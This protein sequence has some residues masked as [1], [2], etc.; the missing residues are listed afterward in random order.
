VPRATHLLAEHADG[1]TVRAIVDRL[2]WSEETIMRL[3]ATVLGDLSP[4]EDT[5]AP[6][7][8][9]LLNSQN[10]FVNRRRDKVAK[11]HREEKIP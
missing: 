7:F 10:G 5:P 3:G 1:D 4:V 2:E 8:V 11:K 9:P 6:V